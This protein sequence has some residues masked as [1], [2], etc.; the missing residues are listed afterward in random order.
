M[1]SYIL[2]NGVYTVGLWVATGDQRGCIFS[3]LFDVPNVRAAHRA[4]NMLNGGEYRSAEI[5]KEH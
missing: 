1:H 5:E 2:S 4:V 3:K